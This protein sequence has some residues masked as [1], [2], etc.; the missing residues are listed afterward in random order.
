[1]N[2]KKLTA[3]AAFATLALSGSA[4]MADDLST[5]TSAE[6]FV[7]GKTRAEVRAEV[8]Q[9]HN[10]GVLQFSNEEQG[11]V[12]TVAQPVAKSTLTR[13]TV[14]AQLLKGPRVPVGELYPAA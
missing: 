5:F 11:Y 12:G 10:A 8:I 1:M 6:H 2:A 9:A 13:D 4:A 14:R 7:A 3:F